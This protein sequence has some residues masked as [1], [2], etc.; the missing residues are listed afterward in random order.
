M[1]ALMASLG[2]V[3]VKVLSLPTGIFLYSTFLVAEHT[4]WSDEIRTN[5][6]SK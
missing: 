4:G 1:S 3:G 5:F 2:C 6:K